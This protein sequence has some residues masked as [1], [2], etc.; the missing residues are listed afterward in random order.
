MLPT[1]LL[2]ERWTPCLLRALANVDGMHLQEVL[3]NVVQALPIRNQ[4]LLRALLAFIASLVNERS[5]KEE[6]GTIC[7]IAYCPTWEADL[8]YGALELFNTVG[9]VLFPARTLEDSAIAAKLLQTFLTYEAMLFSSSSTAVVTAMLKVQHA[10]T[11]A[12]YPF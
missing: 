11:Q 8:P 1:P 5:G 3:R 10:H 4:T 2:G 12:A 6:A 7:G 9:S